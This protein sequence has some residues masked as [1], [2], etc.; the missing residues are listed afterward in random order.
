MSRIMNRNLSRRAGYALAALSI[1]SCSGEGI[2]GTD[3][4]D[5]NDLTADASIIASVSVSFGSSSIAVGDTTKATATLRDWRNRPLPNW[6]VTWSSSDNAIAT[7]SS[8]G[9]VTGT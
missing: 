2:T 8:T 5:T 9:L 4:I 1:F 7:V 6:A 3:A